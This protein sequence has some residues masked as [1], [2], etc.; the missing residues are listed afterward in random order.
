VA[1]VDPGPL[2][3]R[4]L[5]LMAEGR[6]RLE[7]GQ[8]AQLLALL[9]NAHRTEGAR[10]LSADDFDPYREPRGQPELSITVGEY[11]RI[12]LGRN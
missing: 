12:V 11:A 9:Y 4:E 8:T 6:A 1:G 7:W 10:A 3:L 5:A 2:T